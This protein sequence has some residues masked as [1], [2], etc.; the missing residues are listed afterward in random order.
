M[1]ENIWKL[2]NVWNWKMYENVEIYA[3]Q[4]PMMSA[5]KY[6]VCIYVKI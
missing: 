2:E 6:N 4:I 3:I 1:F 5:T